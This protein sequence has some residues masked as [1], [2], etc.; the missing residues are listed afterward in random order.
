MFSSGLLLQLLVSSLPKD[1]KTALPVLGMMMFT[2]NDHV[3]GYVSCDKDQPQIQLWLHAG[4]ICAHTNA[5]IL[6]QHAGVCAVEELVA[7]ADR[8]H[9]R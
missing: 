6:V 8:H 5:C 2:L 1:D 9:I 7:D 3:K 4:A